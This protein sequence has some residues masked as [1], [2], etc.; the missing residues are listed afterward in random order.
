MK[1]IKYRAWDTSS[2]GNTGQMIC[3]D[4]LKDCTMEEILEAY[5]ETLMQFTGVK[6]KEG[7][8]I[9]EGDIV[10]IKTYLNMKTVRSEVTFG[11][12][13]FIADGEVISNWT[14]IKVLG[15]KYENPDLCP[16]K[17]EEKVEAEEEK[18]GDE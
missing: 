3:W 12:G 6:D 7:V 16:K 8:E 13:T 14:D 15:N 11:E 4:E 17:D 5:P 2:T 10:E 1:E 9:C 18:N